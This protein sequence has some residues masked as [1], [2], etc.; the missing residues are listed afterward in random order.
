MLAIFNLLPI[1]PL[2]GHHVLSYLAPPSLRPLIDNPIWMY[3]LLALV[4][5]PY[6]TQNDL[7]A[8]RGADYA[9]CSVYGTFPDRMAMMTV[10]LRQPIV[11]IDGPAGSGK[12]TVARLA[13]RGA[14]LQFIS[15]GALYRAVALRALRAG[16]AATDRARLIALAGE[17]D[18][19]FTLDADGEVHSCLDGEEVTEALQQP[20]VAQVA[21][22]IALIPELR[23]HLVAKLR[24]YGRRGGMVMEGRDI[25]TVVFPEA[26]IKIFLLASARKSALAVAGRNWPRAATRAV[27][28]PCWRTCARAMH[29]TKRVPPRHCAPRRMPSGSTPTGKPSTRW[30]CAC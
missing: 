18:L 6:L 27:M 7:G 21:S 10:H 13:A 15:S 25:Q 30:C 17:V 4:F 8:H 5:I 14:G 28:R 9:K 19:H 1:Y 29:A 16:V 26:E 12:S 2:D 11:A 20:A 3:I 23:A 24:A 22:A